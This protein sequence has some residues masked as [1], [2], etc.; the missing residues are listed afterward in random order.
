[1]LARRGSANGVGSL[2][3]PQL[4]FLGP[5]THRT[6]PAVHG[7]PPRQGVVHVRVGMHTGPV[8]GTLVGAT[9]RKYTLLGGKLFSSSFLLRPAAFREPA[10]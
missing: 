8:V 3:L 10:L 4:R 2:V 5:P 7:R 6:S 1:M 9:R